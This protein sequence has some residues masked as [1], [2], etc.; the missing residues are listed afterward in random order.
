MTEHS[1]LALFEPRQTPQHPVKMD[2][3]AELKHRESSSQS[4]SLRL[5]QDRVLAKLLQ[6][7]EKE[8]AAVAERNGPLQLLDLPVDILK[9]IIREITHTNDLASLA[10]THSALHELVIPCIYSRFDIV[11][12]DLHTAA[13]TRTGVDALTY[14]LATLVMAE[15]VFG[16]APSQHNA[17]SHVHRCSH[18]GR[19]DQCSH[20]PSRSPTP[21]RR[22]TRR[23][24]H[25]AQYT[26]K[27]SLGNGP[28]DWVQEY[29]ITKEGGKMLGTLVALAVGRMRNLESF[30]WDMPTGVLRDVWLALA[31]LGDR[32]DGR[33]CR[34]ERVWVRWH[35]N[36][37]APP[38]SPL[39][40]SPPPANPALVISTSSILPIFH[41]P[42]YPRVEFPTFSVLPPL[43]SL[44][45]LDV[46]ELPYVEE[47]SVLIERSI[48]KLRE[49]RIGIAQHAQF[50]DWVRPAEDRLTVS[51]PPPPN[52]SS[53]HTSRPGGALGLL[54]GFFC[55]AS[56]SKTTA[57]EPPKIEGELDFSDT[58]PNDHMNPEDSTSNDQAESYP[59]IP[60]PHRET[61]PVSMPDLK[62]QLVDNDGRGSFITSEAKVDL[63]S[64]AFAAQALDE[65]VDSER[66]L[67]RNP[68]DDE[69]LHTPT[70]KSTLSESFP[71]ADD[72]S[73]TPKPT[74]KQSKGESEPLAAP[75]HGELEE[76]RS[77]A[78]GPTLK[79]E[80][81]VLELERVPISIPVLSSAIDWSRLT[82]LTILGCRN[83][84]QLWKA[85]RNKFTP[86]SGSRNSTSSKRL[87]SGPRGSFRRSLSDT[88]GGYSTTGALQTPTPREDYP[89]K[90]RR[91]HTDAVSPALIVFI[92]ETLAP[93]T[94]EW[95][96]LQDGRPYK[97]PV[98][99]DHICRAFRR[100]KGSLR[101]LLIDSE[102][103]LDDGSPGP[104][105]NWRRWM[106]NREVLTFIT[107]GRMINLRELGMVLDYK[108]W[109]FFLQ[110]LPYTT[111]LR[112]LFIPYVA[113][114]IH[115]RSDP[116]ELA[117]QI[118]DIVALRPELELCYLGIQSKCFEILEYPA[119]RKPSI[120]D[121]ASG[122]QGSGDSDASDDD[123][124]GSP[125]HTSPIPP[126]HHDT[127]SDLASSRGGDTDDEYED[128][129]SKATKQFK[130][131]EILFYDDK[132]SIFKARHGRL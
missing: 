15:D 126:I 122:P 111:H 16:E 109:H 35:D 63:L 112:S 49:L 37:E 4:S 106:F 5:K 71:A 70:K 12:P 46:D 8:W 61:I 116:R 62:E 83:H 82:C 17:F 54:L 40:S 75:L 38:P 18:C 128:L 7:K 56:R 96:F 55:D 90:I 42:P 19:L 1:D 98:S 76:A 125:H 68:S 101:K 127:D 26:R 88:P 78:L 93:D 118:L 47:M 103:R 14:G 80:L 121:M 33:E 13:D 60:P 9:E 29:Q 41:I 131:R 119:G 10:L 102:D 65:W 92:K 123:G 130:L 58:Y 85:L 20:R 57:Y 91:L 100:H 59:T 44:S 21:F 34:L 28:P 74:S 84:E 36:S 89:L 124:E 104:N 108:D 50:D 114:H 53:H 105:A 117:M 27:F 64:S 113:E 48:P 67:G 52:V 69:V 22:K 45:V 97:S 129:A 43:K 72:P 24:N 51:A 66:R 31:S 39:T 95:L 2:G 99:I 115:G 77:R 23:G 30:I 94:L 132:V 110:R 25:F 79:L 73:P 32:N 3:V 11:W 120:V 87:S 107:S 6:G 81:E 86:Q